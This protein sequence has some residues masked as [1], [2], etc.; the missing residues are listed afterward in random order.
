[1]GS[2]A[3][4]RRRAAVRVDDA[5]IQGLVEKAR[6]KIFKKGAASG[7]ETVDHLLKEKSLQPVRVSICQSRVPSCD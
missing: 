7:G 6:E 3:D 5:E 2:V 4:K 1:M